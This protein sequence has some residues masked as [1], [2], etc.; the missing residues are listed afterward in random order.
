M[1]KQTIKGSSMGLMSRH[2]AA[3]LVTKQDA[4]GCNSVDTKCKNQRVTSRFQSDANITKHAYMSKVRRDRITCSQS[5]KV[6]KG[7][8][9]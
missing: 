2:E 6:V 7:P 9:S 5:G 3:C 8:F 1:P 4:H